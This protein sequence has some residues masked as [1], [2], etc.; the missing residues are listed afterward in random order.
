MGPVVTLFFFLNFYSSLIPEAGGAPLVSFSSIFTASL[1]I[2]LYEC[3]DI[4]GFYLQCEIPWR[5]VSSLYDEGM[6]LQRE[7]QQLLLQLQQQQ[8]Q[9][10]QLH[11]QS[12]AN[13]SSGAGSNSRGSS[14][15]QLKWA[16][17]KL[18]QANK[19]KSLAEIQAEEQEQLAKV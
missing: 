4:E 14:S 3:V 16:D 10:S 7:Q 17:R 8:H 13:E 6:L 2:C 1:H 15:L 9:Q 5:E 19:V 12:L 18:I 11:L